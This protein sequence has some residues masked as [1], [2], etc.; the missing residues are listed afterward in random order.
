MHCSLEKGG[1]ACIIA[2]IMYV[3]EQLLVIEECMDTVQMSSQQVIS[4][5]KILPL[6]VPES[7][8]YM[9]LIM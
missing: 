7:T 1:F 2:N 9:V 4:D 5:H 8:R 6:I 3:V